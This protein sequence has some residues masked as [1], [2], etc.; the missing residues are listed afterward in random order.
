MI[1]ERA[2]ETSVATA[3]FPAVRLFIRR[4][5]GICKILGSEWTAD[6]MFSAVMTVLFLS[7]FVH[8]RLE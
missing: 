4:S 1:G 5:D 3:V 2:F 7:Q 6:A 8:L